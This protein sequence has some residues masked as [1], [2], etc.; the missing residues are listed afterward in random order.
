MR[1]IVTPVSFSPATI[2]RWMGAAPRLGMVNVHASLLPAYRGA[3]PI[4]RAIVAGEKETGVTIM[5]IVRALD[6]G[7]MIAKA[8]RPVGQN[9]TSVEVERDLADLGAHLLIGTLEA[10]TLGSAIEEPQDEALATYAARLTRAESALD[11]SLPAGMIHNR[12][13]GLQPWPRVVTSLKGARLILHR[14]AVPGVVTRAL[15]GSVTHV[16]IH[17]IRVACGDGY[18]LEV[19]ALQPDGRKVMSIRELVA[20]HAVAVGDQLV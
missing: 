6:A 1:M 8:S 20:G 10:L 18:A 13:R 15:P 4:Q 3:A 2:A 12:V 19:L 5:R 11:W 17:M 16:D 7:P 9:E 14:T